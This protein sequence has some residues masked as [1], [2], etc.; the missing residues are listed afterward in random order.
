MHSVS[1]EPLFCFTVEP[2]AK[3]ER[4]VLRA[5]E[6]PQPKGRQP[7]MAAC[8]FFKAG[9]TLGIARRFEKSTSR[10]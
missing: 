5:H 2:V 7:L 4:T 3:V 8:D 1:A 6:A 10:S 9:T